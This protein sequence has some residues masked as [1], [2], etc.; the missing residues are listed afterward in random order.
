MTQLADLVVR[1]YEPEM[2]EAWQRFV[3]ASPTA[4]AAHL[5]EWR[6]ILLRACGA[7]PCYLLATSNGK[8]KGILPMAR[9]PSP[10]GR[11]R[12]VSVPYLTYGGICAANNQAHDALLASASVLARTLGTVVELRGGRERASN[13]SRRVDKATLVLDI[14]DGPAVAWKRFRAEI[15]N[16]IRKARRAGLET[17]V[18]GAECLTEF[19]DVFCRR[20]REL[21]SPPHSYRFFD[22]ILRELPDTRIILVR[23]NDTTVGGGVLC[24][25][26]HSV[27][28]PW[29]AC[30][31]D[32]LWACPYHL[33]YWEAI[34]Y[35]WQ[36]GVKRFDFGR[37]TLDS[38]TFVFKRRWGAEPVP[39]SWHY[40]GANGNGRAN[41]R[42][43]RPLLVASELWKRLPLSATRFIG[44]A[45]RRYLA[46]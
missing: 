28:V 5:I 9:V 30:R 43:G 6:D 4:T 14:A 10:V 36:R 31:G 38:G 25:F 40:I 45:L 39:L 13:G 21:G 32:S 33:L 27:E 24:F 41:G 42:H 29:V 2:R 26:K 3:L 7:R 19:F 23:K 16:R 20:M 1:P 46:E 8:V 34:A 22:E 15:R 12:L 18:G 44:P 37:S 35:S 17:L 11:G